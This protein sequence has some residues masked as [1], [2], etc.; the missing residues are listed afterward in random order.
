MYRPS[1]RFVLSYHNKTYVDYLSPRLLK[2]ETIFYVFYEAWTLLHVAENN[3]VDVAF[4]LK[5]QVS[6]LLHNNPLILRHV[7]PLSKTSMKIY[8]KLRGS[9][10]VNNIIQQGMPSSPAR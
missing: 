7:H 6:M 9:G 10:Q 4:Q 5:Y 3:I 1:A 8:I 2:Y